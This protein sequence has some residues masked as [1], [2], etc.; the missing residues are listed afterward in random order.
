MIPWP[1]QDGVPRGA[2]LQAMLRGSCVRRATWCV[3]G[4]R[5]VLGHCACDGLPLPQDKA[6]FT[7]A[8]RLILSGP[9]PCQWGSGSFALQ[10]WSGSREWAVASLGVRTP[11]K[12]P[13]PVS[14]IQA[15]I[16]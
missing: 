3:G 2:H 7:V 13:R 1:L 12:N 16:A 8:R 5:A 10:G 15:Y 9:E 11:S 14:E 4:M 6:R